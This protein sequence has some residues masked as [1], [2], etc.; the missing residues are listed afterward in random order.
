MPIYKM[1]GKK[2]GLQKYNVR[3]NYIS[4]IGKP[5]QL[6]RT[7]Y[8]LDAAKELERRLEYDF[9][10]NDEVLTRKMS[11]KQLFDE[12]IKVKQ[13]E[14]RETTLDKTKRI[15]KRHVIPKLADVSIDKMSVKILQEWKV[16]LEEQGLALKT[17][18]NVF[19]ELR[20]ML[21]YAVKMEYIPK[22]PLAKVGNFRSALST[23]QEI[24]FYTPE[25]FRKFINVAKDIA[26][27][28]QG[29]SQSLYEWNYYVFFS[30]AFYTGLRKGEIHA[31]RWSDIE[32]GYLSVKRSLTQKLHHKDIETPPKNRSSFRTLQMPTPLIEILNEHKIRQQ[33]LT[34]FKDNSMVLGDGRSLR[35]TSI[36]NRNIQYASLAGVKRI[37]IHDFRHSHASLL[38]NM[39]INI[40][41]IARRLGHA[42]I[43]MTWNTYS[44]LYPKEEEKAMAVLNKV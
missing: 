31:L 34:D 5:K 41:E 2:D 15:I 7:T 9:K 30:I 43:E 24:S 40:Q 23:K 25:E 32:N 19:S 3:I 26:L 35:D 42:R 17:K 33:Q 36:Q 29:K 1:N 6:T 11:I 28:K 8:G 37:R 4:D 21:N 38:A 10:V 13:Y 14:V 22:N 39:G 16:S 27:K 44:H 18:K 20:S 12:Y